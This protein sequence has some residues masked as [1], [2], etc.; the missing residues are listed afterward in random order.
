M[1]VSLVLPL[2]SQESRVEKKHI[3]G[4]HLSMMLVSVGNDN[5]NCVQQIRDTL[6]NC[7]I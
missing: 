2:S 7:F 1:L 3:D 6:S 5:R 4:Q